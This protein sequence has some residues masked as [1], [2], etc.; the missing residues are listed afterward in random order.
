M[1]D[2]DFIGIGL[3]PYNLG[4]ACLTAP[5]TELDGVF[6][7][8]R[9]DV[10]WHPGMMLDG[11]RLQT[12][13]LADLVTLADPTSPFSFLSYLK[14]SG[15]MYSF[16][17]RESFY[18]LR[19]EYSDYCRWAA[20]KLPNLRFGTRVTAITFADDMYVVRA[21]DAEFRAPR[22]VLGTGTPPTCR[23][24]S[25]V[26]AATCCTIPTTWTTATRCAPNAASPFSAAGRA[27]RR[28]TRT[29]S[30]ASNPADTN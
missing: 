23:R 18:P 5:I 28:S 26:W 20:A 30:P 8:A 14:E 15:R 4:L 17:I 3:G 25:A 16:Y 21:G 11:T 24:R 2:H 12:P 19:N 7:E 6:L 13:F 22:L 29:C 9:T 27:R 1:S 10:S